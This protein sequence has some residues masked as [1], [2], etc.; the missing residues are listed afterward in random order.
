MKN[1]KKIMS[2][3]FLASAVGYT[4]FASAHSVSGTLGRSDSGAAATDVYQVDCG[5]L[6]AKVALQVN[7][8]APKNPSLVSVLAVKGKSASQLITD[9]TENGVAT[10]EVTFAPAIGKGVYTLIVAKSPS[11]KKGVEKYKATI[12]CNLANGEHTEKT[13][14]TQVQDQ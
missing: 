4:G 7:D 11:T 6:A 3:V 8:Q 10:P 1:Y 12:H 5:A 9:P 14:P 13:E 2:V